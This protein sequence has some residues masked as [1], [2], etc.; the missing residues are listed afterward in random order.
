ML[1]GL[2][3]EID[4]FHGSDAAIYQLPTI[5]QFR[6]GLDFSDYPSAQTPLFHLV[7]AGWGKLVGFELWRLRLL[8]VAIS[9]GA[10]LALLRLL[11]RTTGLDDL[12]ALALTLAFVLSPYFFGAPSRCSRTTWRSCSRCWRSSA[13]TATPRTGRRRRSPRPAS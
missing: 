1:Q 13:C 10:A 3:V 4:T 12:P 6:E 5:L 7:M 8:N 9:Y 2:T 11:R